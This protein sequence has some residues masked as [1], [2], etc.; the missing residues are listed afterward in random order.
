[1]LRRIPE[2][3]RK[4]GKALTLAQITGSLNATMN[5]T[6]YGTGS[7]ARSK[8]KPWEYHL[9]YDEVRLILKR[10]MARLVIEK[11]TNR[12]K[13][14]PKKGRIRYALINPLVALA[15]VALDF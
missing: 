9:E 14:D 10:L 3:I 15:K 7:R 4:D 1:M 2:L 13:Y 12:R 8:W 5:P 11:D 6:Y